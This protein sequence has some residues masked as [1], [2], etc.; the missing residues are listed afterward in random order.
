MSKEAVSSET[1]VLWFF[2]IQNNIRSDYLTEMKINGHHQQTA[3]PKGSATKHV[4]H[5]YV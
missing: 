3:S 1:N 2:A 4:S 5:F